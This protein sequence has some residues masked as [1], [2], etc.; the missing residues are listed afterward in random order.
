MSASRST[1]VSAAGA[2][3]FSERKLLVAMLDMAGYTRAVREARAVDVAVFLDRFYRA[4]HE[5]VAGA[6]GRVVKF[7]GDACLAVF[8]PEQC[9][10]ALDALRG[11]RVEVDRLGAA[12]HLA[13][14]GGHTNVHLCTVVEGEFGAPGQRRYD[15]LGEGV[16][17]V[18]LMGRGAGVHIS[19]PV[20]RRLPSA[21]RAGWK[22]NKPPATYTRA[23]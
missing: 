19:E 8:P 13:V 2:A 9:A 23:D 4:C 7:M 14:T 11:L 1:A 6:G 15:V 18:F 17:H 20:Y 5:A 3:A 12:H 16:N 10:A 21:R 22:K